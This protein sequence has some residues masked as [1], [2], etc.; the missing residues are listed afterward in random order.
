MA[1]NNFSLNFDGF[2]DLAREIDSLGEGYLKQAVEN[3]FTKSKEYVN[4]EIEK[5]MA[6]SRYNFDKGQGYSQGRMKASFEEVSKMPIEWNGSVITA[7]IGV[8]TSDALESIFLIY[9]SPNTPKDTKLYN[10]MKVKGKVKKEVERIQMEE[11][12]KVIQEA[13]ND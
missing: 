3:A 6:N 11:F 7:S 9:G 5:A 2:L 1:K 4:D 12:Q 13:I 10:A 8:K